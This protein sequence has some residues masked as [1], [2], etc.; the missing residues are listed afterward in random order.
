MASNATR[1]AGRGGIC[2]FPRRRPSPPPPLCAALGPAPARKGIY[3]KP[4]VQ[5][6]MK[7]PAR[8][9]SKREPARAQSDTRAKGVGEIVV[10]VSCA[11]LRFGP[12]EFTFVKGLVLL[13]VGPELSLRG[14]CCLLSRDG[15]RFEL[16]AGEKGVSLQKS[17]SQ[18]RGRAERG[19]HYPQREEMPRACGQTG[20]ERAA[21]TAAEPPSSPRTLR[22][23]GLFVILRA[24]STQ[25]TPDGPHLGGACWTPGMAFAKDAEAN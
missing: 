18:T 15:S 10:F 13:L 5:R 25:P 19:R 17:R 4:L 6:P 24:L 21:T 7:E 14:A 16:A 3:A 11:Q 9:A 12:G 20:S 1:V 22:R 23:G 8:E 2:D